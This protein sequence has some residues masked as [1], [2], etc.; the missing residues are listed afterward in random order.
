ME[1]KKKSA[2]KIGWLMISRETKWMFGNRVPGRLTLQPRLFCTFRILFLVCIATLKIK[3]NGLLN[4]DLFKNERKEQM[5][6]KEV[7]PQN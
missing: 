4:E 7:R 1:M 2:Q 3:S 6:Q 5:E